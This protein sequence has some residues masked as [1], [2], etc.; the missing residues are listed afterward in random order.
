MKACLWLCA[1]LA[2]TG[3]R[4]SALQTN[5][6][7]RSSPASS[8]ATLPSVEPIRESYPIVRDMAPGDQF[9][10]GKWDIHL[11]PTE[12]S[13]SVG[14]LSGTG[15]TTL[16]PAGWRAAKGCFVCVESPQRLW[17]YNGVADLTLFQRDAESIGTFGPR[18]FPCEIPQLVAMK[19]P[20]DVY[21]R[22]KPSGRGR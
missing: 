1:F 14:A 18:L 19:L 17:V 3:C 9:T 4:H 5:A 6:T 10:D 21:E 20:S 8:A 12:G 11:S 16:R 15:S 13:L 22:V 7:S 2:L